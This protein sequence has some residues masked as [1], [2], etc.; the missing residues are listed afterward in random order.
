[1]STEVRLA[2]IASVQY[3]P[4][5]APAGRTPSPYIDQWAPA[6]GGARGVFRTAV[7]RPG[8]VIAVVFVAFAVSTAFVPWLFASQSPSA[9]D[10]KA[11]LQAPSG[12][13]WFGT[14]QLGRDL[15]AR[16]V[17][18]SALTIQATLIAIGIAFVAG[19]TLGVLA[20]FVG[21]W[22]DAVLMRAVDVLLAI[23]GLLLALALVTAL[24]FGTVPVAVA[25]GIGIVP[26]FARTT[27]S[28]VLRV[29]T[30]PYVE[31][32][33][34][35]GVRPWTIVLRHVL[36]N[37]W[38]PVIVLSVLDFGAA[39][40]AIASLSFLGFGAQPPA[41]EWGSLIADG[42]AYLVTAPWVSLLPGLF[43]AL[44]VFSL[45]HIA[46]AIEGARR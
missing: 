32:A 35:A 40:L 21:G 12:V 9:T 10:P 44:V 11:I 23:P 31:A 22:L 13:H 20:G 37:S 28:E 30:L 45:N 1:M 7:R 34:V 29:T 17:D 8:L 39:I 38:G 33:R 19:L 5:Q 2:P 14:D 4:G 43:V 46:R 18:G 42:R 27:R 6:G 26:G 41:S 25:V 36:P 24:G 16:V 15:W 3:T